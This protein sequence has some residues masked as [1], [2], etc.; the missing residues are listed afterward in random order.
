MQSQHDLMTSFDPAV[1]VAF[2]SAEIGASATIKAASIQA[3][4]AIRAAE[5]AAD[6]AWK[7]SYIQL[8]I[9]LLTAVTA[10]IVGCLAYKGVMKAALTQVQ[11]D[12]DK[13]NDRV[14]AY[15]FRQGV[16]SWDIAFKSSLALYKAD[17]ML[18]LYR[19]CK[20][21]WL[22]EISFFIEPC[23]W[24]TDRW[25]DHALLGEKFVQLLHNARLA[26]EEFSQFH[27]EVKSD[28]LKCDSYTST[29][30]IKSSGEICNKND[31]GIEIEIENENVVE[32]NAS[33]IKKLHDHTMNLSFYIDPKKTAKSIIPTEVIG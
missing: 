12:K 32:Q 4:A 16:V 26:L 19:N 11:L 23:E 1:W 9:A 3:E 24:S 20:G 22:M 15:R 2:E 29:P 25:E 10:L 6:V 21:S 31:G 17:E 18:E 7:V 8:G 33:L 30:T 5:I 27:R 14:A 13:H 28:N